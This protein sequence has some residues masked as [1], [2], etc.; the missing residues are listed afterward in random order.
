MFQFSIGN[1]HTDN[2]SVFH[3]MFRGGPG[4][5]EGIRW[6]LHDVWGLLTPSPILDVLFLKK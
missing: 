4:A 1:L 5:G 6:D 2:K 3:T